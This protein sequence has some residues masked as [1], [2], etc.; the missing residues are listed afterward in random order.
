MESFYG[1]RPGNSFILAATFQTVA[2]MVSAF[3]DG[4]SYEDVKFDEYVM[5]DGENSDKGKLY[6]RGYD[7]TNN[8]TG[9]AIYI[10]NITGPQG[11]PANIKMVDWNDQTGQYTI[12]QLSLSNGGLVEADNDHT[13]IKYKYLNVNNNTHDTNL[14]LQIPYPK[15]KAQVS[16]EISTV[17]NITIAPITGKPFQYTATF[18]FPNLK[19]DSV[20]N[21]FVTTLNNLDNNIEVINLP[22]NFP[23]NEPF[24][25]CI[26]EKN[27]SGDLEYHYITKYS[28]IESM[29]VN[30]SGHLVYALPGGG[31][32]ESTNSVVPIINGFNLSAD[33]RLT[34][35]YQNAT[36]IQTQSVTPEQYLRW[37]TGLKIENN[38]LKVVWNNEIDNTQ[39]QSTVT[40]PNNDESLITDIIC[41]ENGSVLYKR[42]LGIVNETPS[43]NEIGFGKEY[44]QENNKLYKRVYDFRDM[45]EQLKSYME[46]MYGNFYLPGDSIVSPLDCSNPQFYIYGNDPTGGTQTGQFTLRMEGQVKAD[47]L[48]SQSVRSAQ[49]SSSTSPVP[50][51]SLKLYKKNG[52]LIS[53]SGNLAFL[54]LPIHW[55]NG[56]HSNAVV[57]GSFSFTVRRGRLYFVREFQ[58]AAD[59]TATGESVTVRN[60]VWTLFKSNYDMT[61]SYFIL[62]GSAIKLS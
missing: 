10:G 18:T 59:Y 48:L 27:G 36:D 54:N 62:R 9:G 57:G 45:L 42:Y 22:E 26:I 34:I 14:A 39:Q 16:Q 53:P 4:P 38:Q 30:S 56:E 19:G 6:R 17:P 52:D 46:N 20:T 51:D 37:I 7:Y 23:D 21:I 40:L 60:Q 15:F 35:N 50:F 25:C 49:Y 31:T 8:E 1:G 58:L 61:K 44:Y 33:G 12:G 5:I 13:T 11:I 43:E 28:I 3:R 2:Q 24:L 41:P 55:E 32:V 47:R 29:S